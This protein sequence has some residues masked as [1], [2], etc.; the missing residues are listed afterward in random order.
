MKLRLMISSIAALSLSAILMTGAL[1][2]GPGPG[3]P[4]PQPAATVTVSTAALSEDEIA[5]L[6]YMVEEEKL[7]H[8]VYVTLYDLWGI[9]IFNN[10]ASSESQHTRAVETLLTR[11]GIADPTEG[12]GVGVFENT[13]LQTLYN[14]LIE[15]GSRSVTDALQAGV[16][17]EETDIADIE[18]YSAELDHADIARVYASLLRGSQ[19][20]LRAFSR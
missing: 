6:L 14:D 13:D 4:A 5:G 1:A 8:D 10:I 16:L 7:A 11:Y 15:M 9:R 12:N 18:Q 19:N 17:I 2:A 3:R 20:H